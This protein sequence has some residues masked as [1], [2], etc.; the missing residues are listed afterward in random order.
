MRALG[1]Q[2][3]GGRNI[4]EVMA[5]KKII[6]LT[7]IQAEILEELDRGEMIVI[8]SMNMAS[9][10]EKSISPQTRYFM[11]DNR[12]VTRK[13]KTKAATTSGNGYVITEKGKKILQ[14]HRERK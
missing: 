2:K 5:A 1:E 4:G 11:T 10:G 12:L 13:D 8:D 3:Y 7:K 6:K 14:E 9:M